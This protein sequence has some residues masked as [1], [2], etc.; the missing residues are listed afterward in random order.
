MARLKNDYPGLLAVSSGDKTVVLEATHNLNTRVAQHRR[1]G[2]HVEVRRECYAYNSKALRNSWFV[3]ELLK[4]RDEGYTIAN[5]R[6]YGMDYPVRCE[7]A[8]LMP[9]VADVALPPVPAHYMTIDDEKLLFN[10]PWTP[11]KSFTTI[12]LC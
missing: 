4:L 7:L 1:D 5:T 2:L 11:A 8:L 12:Y 3:D 6:F 10:K 9:E